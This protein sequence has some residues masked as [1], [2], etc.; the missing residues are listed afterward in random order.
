MI[1]HTFTLN[2]TTKK[3][4][5]AMN[6]SLLFVFLFLFTI[7]TMMAQVPFDCPDMLYQFK[8]GNIVRVDID[9]NS[10]SVIGSSS[11]IISARGYNVEND[12]VYIYS[13]D[14]LYRIDANWNKTTMG[15]VSG[16]MDSESGDFDDSGNFFIY[17]PGKLRSI[18]VDNPP[19]TATNYT[20]TGTT[21]IGEINDIAFRPADG[22]FYGISKTGRKLVTIT[23]TG[24]GTATISHIPTTGPLKN[25]SGSADYGTAWVTRSDQFIVTNQWSGKIYEVNFQTGASVKRQ[26]S[27][28]LSLF[29]DGFSCS[30]PLEVA[31]GTMNQ[32]NASVPTTV[33]GNGGN[34]DWIKIKDSDGDLIAAIEN[35]ENLGTVSAEYY[36]HPDGNRMNDEDVNYLGRNISIQVT[37]Q[38]TNPVKVRL[39]FKESEYTALQNASDS[40]IPNSLDI[41]DLNI[42]KYSGS[43][44]NSDVTN[45]GGGAVLVPN[46]SQSTVST[47][48]F[49]IQTRVSSFSQFFIHESNGNPLPVELLSFDAS[50]GNNKSVDLTWETASE[51]DNDYF[52]LE[53]STDGREWKTFAEVNGAGNSI[54]TLSYSYTDEEPYEGISYYR[55]KQTD[56][57]GQYEYSN[58]ETV[59]RLGVKQGIKVYP[60]PTNG[61]LRLLENSEG[62]Y[63][64]TNLLGQVQKQGWVEVDGMINTSDLSK[65]QY[66]LQI[67]DSNNETSQVKFV[68]VD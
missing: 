8:S 40:S 6:K 18:D 17:A 32:C 53:K 60:N 56:Y 5:I 34:G 15:N 39:Y 36:L 55:L 50:S 16:G 27:S 54:E 25:E 23:I 7:G 48:G 35:K 49:Y 4:I 62:R 44:C 29:N 61:I 45:A 9:N 21:G 3:N 33:N 10:E 22:K 30:K 67:T 63:S 64:I 2:T 38:P 24:P 42:T 66:I 47:D 57:D 65:G 19:Y 31:S 46:E 1:M 20:L 13:D 12:F 37:N 59:N 41:S 68:K 26:T 14:R 43:N 11:Y 52:S 51:E 58:I 28:V